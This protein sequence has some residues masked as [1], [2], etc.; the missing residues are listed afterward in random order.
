MGLSQSNTKK[1]PIISRFPDVETRINKMFNTNKNNN[2][3]TEGSINTFDLDDNI[4]NQ[5]KV[6][7]AVNVGRGTF[8]FSG[9]ADIPSYNSIL[10]EGRGKEYIP[11]K[12]TYNKYDPIELKKYL[13]NG[14]DIKNLSESSADSENFTQME[15]MRN[16]LT[17]DINNQKINQV[18]L[19]TGGRGNN[20][21]AIFDNIESP[22]TTTSVNF[23]DILK[24]IT[25]IANITNKNLKGGQRRKE[26][27]DNF[28]EEPVTET[29]D[30]DDDDTETGEE[31]DDEE[32]EAEEEDS[33]DS[34]DSSTSSQNENTYNDYSETSNNENEGLVPFYSEDGSDYEFR[35]AT[36]L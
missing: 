25:N 18:H 33:N 32:P 17:N 26:E 15:Q 11:R 36:H 12:I 19:A 6:Y 10:K 13:Q 20:L 31:D 34:N 4:D 23:K 16:Y 8:G 29:F 2:L 35:Q 14:G 21:K 27:P 9:R 5:K 28:F 30:L 3:Y 22:T 24:N 7:S 1:Y